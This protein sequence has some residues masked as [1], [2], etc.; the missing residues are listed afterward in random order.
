MK[1]DDLISMIL[2]LGVIPITIVLV[3]FFIQ[4][5]KH[6]ERMTLIEKGI[7]IDTLERKNSPFQDVL[8]WGMLAGGIGLGLLIA[9]FLLEIKV[10][11]DDMI[12]GILAMIFGGISLIS[13]YI[14]KR[15]IEKN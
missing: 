11:K 6:K 9:Y 4:K 1:A 12:L 3:L 15:R 7:N 5:S 14:I 8:L 10:C 13:Y 2:I